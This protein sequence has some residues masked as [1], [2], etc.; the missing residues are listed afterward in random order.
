M[1]RCIHPVVTISY[2]FVLTFMGLCLFCVAA[3]S[4]Q[5]DSTRKVL[6]LNSY[7]KGKGTGIGL[8]VVYGIVK[9]YG[10]EIEVETKIGSGTT[11]KQIRILLML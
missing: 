1:A 6:I 5:P 4:A 8:A 11:F 7:H 10:G 9:E 3:V 2:K